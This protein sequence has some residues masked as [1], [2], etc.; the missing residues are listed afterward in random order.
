M[1]MSNRKVGKNGKNTYYA[2][3]DDAG[4]Y[5]L[6]L[7]GTYNGAWEVSK[8]RRAKSGRRGYHHIDSVWNYY[9]TV[10]GSSGNDVIK[11]VKQQAITGK[12]HKDKTVG[13][14]S[15]DLYAAETFYGHGGNDKLFGYG[16]NDTL[17]GGTGNDTL[18]GGSGDDDLRGGADN[19]LFLNSRGND[20]IDG[21]TGFDTVDYTK[22]SYTYIMG[23]GYTADFETETSNG[24]NLTAL[25]ATT[26]EVSDGLDFFDG[27]QWVPSK[28][29][30]TNIEHVIGTVHVD[31][32]D[33]SGYKSNISFDGG[34]GNDIL[35]GGDGND[36]LRG[37]DGTDELKGGN[38]NDTIFSGDLSKGSSDKLWGG[39]GADTFYMGEITKST[40]VTKTIPNE[41]T[42]GNWGLDVLAD[43]AF[44]AAVE[45]IPGAGLFERVV[46]NAIPQAINGLHAT[47]DNDWNNPSIVKETIADATQSTYAEIM[48]F[49]PLK[50]VV[51]IPLA[52]EGQPNVSL[53]GDVASA[54]T[55]T[56]NNGNGQFG[57]L[58]F[59]PTLNLSKTA[60]QFYQNYLIDSALIIDNSGVSYG[61]GDNST[62]LT[63]ED[64]VKTELQKMK[65][66]FMILGAYS[67]QVVK[68]LAYIVDDTFYGTDR[69]DVFY[70]YEPKSDKKGSHFQPE[71]F[72]SETF[73]GWDG[74]DLFYGGNGNN[75]F[76]GG[77]N[78]GTV[79]NDS[80]TVSYADANNYGIDVDLSDVTNGDN[81][82]YTEVWN[83]FETD[84]NNRGVDRLYDIE[85]IIGSKFVD[86]IIGNE[87]ANTFAGGKSDDTLKGMG[88]NDIL[89]GGQG[90]DNLWGG[91]GKDTFVLT[92]LSRPDVDVINDFDVNEDTLQINT[93]DSISLQSEKAGTGVYVDS[94]KVA[95]LKGVTASQVKLASYNINDGALIGSDW[96]LIGA[97]DFDG[98]G[99]DD[100]LW[101]HKDGLVH[102]WKMQNG[103]RV[104]SSN[105][106]NGALIG[107]DW[108]LIGAGDFDGD[109]DDDILWQHKDGLVH[110]WE[111]QNGDRVAGANLHN[112]ALIGSDWNLIG[113]GDFDGDGDD[114]IL[115]QHK[116]GLVHQWKMQNG[117]R[118]ASANLIST[119]LVNSLG[120]G[121]TFIGAGDFD[122]NG[123][124]SLLWQRDNGQVFAVDNIHNL[125][126]T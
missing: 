87:K 70:G 77:D 7:N 31:T 4:S 79:Y 99:D 25:D 21:G 47:L 105:L 61:G 53:A 40:T 48:D 69:S 62:S 42:S 125:V 8:D 39:A 98:D 12:V 41:N 37:G 22:Y 16:G 74:N 36:T 103:D 18:D 29:K 97:G 112:G 23:G 90:S 27:S 126:I 102:Q 73:F 116:D 50:D 20:K 6:G 57:A 3:L 109:G 58:N 44:G 49:N 119:E 83:G 45:L 52:A 24:I 68:D 100:I 64:S 122:G 67:G 13:T 33:A 76:F 46:K 111:M 107:S 110:Q 17:D 51:I 93:Q 56:Y 72:E 55:F 14:A 91:E 124:E 89:I 95:L 15:F 71:K 28:D 1:A 96:N 106:Y 5:T 115:W 113:A 34:V 38:G 81:G 26:L 84:N 60:K 63:L 19:D 11:G 59:D 65:G 75:T 54:L 30:L 10:N 123:S 120:S 43:L 66:R 2:Q 78:L 104:A 118:V 88:G 101:Q 85:N 86:T 32:L 92:D 82:D 117:D 35:T 9:S 114:D 80:D 94:Q 108:N 121:S